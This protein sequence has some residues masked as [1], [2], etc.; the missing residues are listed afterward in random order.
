MEGWMDICLLPQIY[1][2]ST[3][4]NASNIVIENVRSLASQADW[5]DAGLVKMEDEATDTEEQACS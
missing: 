4:H 2:K 3:L 1:S 5:E